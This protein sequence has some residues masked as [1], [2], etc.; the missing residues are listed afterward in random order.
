MKF[1]GSNV[2]SFRLWTGVRGVR[3]HVTQVDDRW[4]YTRG[5]YKLPHTHTR[6]HGPSYTRPD[7]H[8]PID[9]YT[10]HPYLPYSSWTHTRI[11]STYGHSLTHSHAC[12]HSHTRNSHDYSH[13]HTRTPPNVPRYGPLQHIHTRVPPYTDTRPV[14]PMTPP[15]SDLSLLRPHSP[16]H[17]CQEPEDS[18]GFQPV[19]GQV[20]PR[21]FGPS[22]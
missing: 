14:C 12:P 9:T 5:K 2:P 20:P 8:F 1:T 10:T 18:M 11:H 4:W 7:T 19:S 16:T 3:S 15:S 13:S 17:R 22:P 21:T 6:T